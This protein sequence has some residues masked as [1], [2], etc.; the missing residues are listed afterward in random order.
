MPLS[1][2]RDPLYLPPDGAGSKWYPQYTE[3]LRGLDVVIIQDNDEAGIGFAQKAASEL[4]EAARSVKVLDLTKIWPE[5]PK[6][7]DASD[8]LN[9]MGK[10]R[11][12]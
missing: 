10:T 11:G 4:I 6:H 12:R 5:L 2:S 9:H 3:S 7:G 1:V 8:L